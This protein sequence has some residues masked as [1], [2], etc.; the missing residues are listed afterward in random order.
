MANSGLCEQSV[1]ARSLELERS[2]ASASEMLPG[3]ADR[4]GAARESVDAAVDT[5]YTNLDALAD[6]LLGSDARQQPAAPPT[7][8]RTS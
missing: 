6:G 3:I 7:A 2:I 5:R 8:A 1:L 4:F